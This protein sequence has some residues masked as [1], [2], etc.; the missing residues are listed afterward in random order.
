M[1]YKLFLL[2]CYSWL[3]I[4]KKQLHRVAVYLTHLRFDEYLMKKVCLYIYEETEALRI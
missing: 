1:L 3:I 2:T 4:N